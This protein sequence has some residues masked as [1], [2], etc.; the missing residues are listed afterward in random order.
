VLEALQT[1][2]PNHPTPVV[3]KKLS[4]FEEF[5]NL[6]KIMALDEHIGRT[7]GK[8]FNLT[9]PHYFRLLL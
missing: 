2:Y 1:K 6:W 9:S 7:I 8:K 3:I 4:V 5:V